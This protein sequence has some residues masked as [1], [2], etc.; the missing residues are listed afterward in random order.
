MRTTLSSQMFILSL[1]SMSP[2]VA[3]EAYSGSKKSI[4][5]MTHM[6]RRVWRMN[7][8]FSSQQPWHPLLFHCATGESRAAFSHLILGKV[9]GPWTGYLPH[10]NCKRNFRNTTGSCI[11][12]LCITTI[13]TVIYHIIVQLHRHNNFANIMFLYQSY[14]AYLILLL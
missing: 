11:Q 13:V 2:K 8:S 6:G 12:N 1:V 4:A 14:I 7:C 5:D 3:D 9:E 10:I